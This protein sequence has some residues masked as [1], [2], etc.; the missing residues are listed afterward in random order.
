MAASLVAH[1][2]WQSAVYALRSVAVRVP[3][4]VKLECMMASVSNS[5]RGRATPK[6]CLSATNV[7]YGICI[8]PEF[9]QDSDHSIAAGDAPAQRTKCE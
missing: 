1:A 9:D 6:A 4:L 5:D 8:A 2:L 3:S 7:C